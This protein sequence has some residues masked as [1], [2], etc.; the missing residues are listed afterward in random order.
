MWADERWTQRSLSDILYTKDKLAEEKIQWNLYNNQK[1]YKIPV[2]TSKDLS[3]N[4]SLNKEIEDI[5]R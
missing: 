4:R 1:L 5:R 3:D 2:V